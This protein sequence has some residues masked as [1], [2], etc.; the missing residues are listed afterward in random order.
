VSDLHQAVQ[1]AIAAHTPTLPPSFAA[2]KARRT[3]Q[4][5]A[6]SAAAVAL[7]AVAVTGVAVVP[8]LIQNSDR[9]PS[10]VAA[11]AVAD[12]RNPDTTTVMGVE[13]R[14]VGSADVT[15]AYTDPQDPSALFVYAGRAPKPGYCADYAAVR[16][17]AQDAQTVTLDAA[18]YEPAT[19]PPPNLA[20]TTTLPPPQQHR[21]NLGIPLDGRRVVDTD[22]HEL[23]VLDTGTLLVPTALPDGY[24]GPGKLTVGYGSS[25]DAGNDVTVHTYAGPDSQTQ[26]EV[27]QGVAD[28]V[29]GRD[30]PVAPSVVVDRPTVRG[31]SAVV[32]ETAGL[33]DLTCLRWRERQN[34]VVLV[35]SRGNPAPLD[36]SA[37]QAVADS[38]RQAR[39]ARG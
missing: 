29:P 1:A 27:Y 7:A 4:A 30:E 34:Y 35:C 5:R 21:L 38:V 8:G 20:C 23:K 18:R 36:S 11:G 25:D 22:G 3:R 16:V 15:G 19:T 33:Q 31:H 6:R 12:G 26:L 39:D 17:A 13:V 9:H 2:L 24:R 14:K 37:L 28:K 32:T 10:G